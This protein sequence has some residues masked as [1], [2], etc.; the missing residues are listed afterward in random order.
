MTCGIVH[1]KEKVLQSLMRTASVKEVSNTICHLT[2]L[3]M[4]SSKI[5]VLFKG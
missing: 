5:F 4:E 1:A 3:D 2:H